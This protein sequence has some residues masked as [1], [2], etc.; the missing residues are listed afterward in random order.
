[1]APASSKTCAICSTTWLFNIGRMLAPS[2]Q[3]EQCLPSLIPVDTG[4]N[5]SLPAKMSRLGVVILINSNAGRRAKSILRWGA[6][7]RLPHRAAAALDA[8]SFRF[9]AERAF[10][11]AMPPFRPPFRPISARY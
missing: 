1:V 6:H 7:F 3:N 4:F 2:G 10:L 9:F 8:I 11:L 5:Y